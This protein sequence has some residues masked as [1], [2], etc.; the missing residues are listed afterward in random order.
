MPD[1]KNDFLLISSYKT[2][3][4]KSYKTHHHMK[5][6][7]EN[8]LYTSILLRLVQPASLFINLISLL[9]FQNTCLPWSLVEQSEIRLFGSSV[10]R[11]ICPD[12]YKVLLSID[13]IS[14]PCATMLVSL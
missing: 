3:E 8:S 9:Y 11:P 7:S 2:I 13:S 5:S 4:D 1:I 6:R 14:I 12:I 10:T